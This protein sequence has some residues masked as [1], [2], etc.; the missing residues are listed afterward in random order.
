MSKLYIIFFSTS[1]LKNAFKQEILCSFQ[2]CRQLGLTGKED[3]ELF[4]DKCQYI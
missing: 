3:S 1:I 4:T 2:L